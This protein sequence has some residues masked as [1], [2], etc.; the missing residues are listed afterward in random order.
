MARVPTSVVYVKSQSFSFSEAAR[1]FLKRQWWIILRIFIELMYSCLNHAL[2]AIITTIRVNT[3][4]PDLNGIPKAGETHM[5]QNI[6]VKIMNIVDLEGLGISVLSSYQY[7]SLGMRRRRSEVLFNH[8][9]GQVAVSL[10]NCHLNSVTGRETL[11]KWLMHHFPL[12]LT[13]L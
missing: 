11:D 6:W 13:T 9:K 3:K 7:K 12:M 2:S 5:D 1:I 10:S 8:M 4:T